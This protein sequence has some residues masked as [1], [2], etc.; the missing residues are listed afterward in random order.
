M[1]QLETVESPRAQPVA[2]GQPEAAP[3]VSATRVAFGLALLS[4]VLLWLCYFPLA[5]GWMG[6]FALA[7]LLVL[8][9]SPA[10]A[11]A[12]YWSAYVGGLLF[13]LAAVQ[14]MRVADD[15][16]YFTWIGLSLYCAGYFPLAIY[17]LRRLD[18]RTRL[19]LT[20]TAPV[21]WTALEYGRATFATGFSWYL[22][23][24]TQHDF[25]HVIQIAD[26]AGVYGVTFLVVLVNA[27]LVETAYAIT[28][29]PT[30]LFGRSPAR[31]S[32]L[33]LGLQIGAT[34][35]V[36]AAALGY[37][38]ARLSHP[39]FTPGP[40]LALLQG[41]MPQQ[42]RNNPAEGVS[43][44]RHFLG[45]ADLA[46]LSHRI[47]LLVFPETSLPDEWK[48]KWPLDAVNDN[49]LL[50]GALREHRW[51]VPTLMGINS[52]VTGPDGLKH[53]YNSALLIDAECSAPLGRY[54]KIHRVPFGEY[55]PLREVLPFMNYL[56]PYDFEYSITSG[57]GHTR[58]PVVTG[59][60]VETFGVV[61]CYEDADPEVARPYGGGDGRKRADF[62]VNISN[63]GWFD[64]TSEHEE[65]LAV[66]RLRAV[67]NRVPVVRA[68]N[69]GVS[70]VIDGDGRVLAPEPVGP[71]AVTAKPGM[72]HDGQKIHVWEVKD[73]A[74]A[75]PLSRW[76][77]FKKT[78]GI[79]L[80][81]P[82]LDARASFY[83]IWGDWLPYTCWGLVVIFLVRSR[84]AVEVRG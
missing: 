26:L 68:V 59:G 6:W 34:V 72:V 58:F 44:V 61:I 77:E 53:R 67:E 29:L 69:M 66:C 79:M 63:D 81:R 8:V 47:D 13:F 80:V 12:V 45:L 55:I 30:A 49:A 75:L 48:E 1:A 43:M 70:A 65:H 73:D 60:K 24:Y 71:G 74:G 41:N 22:V 9:R 31:G 11:W 52:E 54:D 19:P 46:A 39:L 84:R 62:L 27:V 78:P 42:V 64:G 23:G 33:G 83:S 10:R 16:M 50:L 5:W 4:G 32:R 7:P 2:S 14:W 15:R 25:L 37:G 56:S 38:S 35:L 28:P 76:G 51:N 21:V 57:Q 18:R 3:A 40:R 36:L 82:P 20:I 17:V